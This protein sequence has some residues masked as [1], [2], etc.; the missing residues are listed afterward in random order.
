MKHDRENGTGKIAELEELE[1]ELEEEAG[2]EFLDDVDTAIG[3]RLFQERI[4]WI[5]GDI[6]NEAAK[7]ICTCILIANIDDRGIAVKDREPIRIFLR[8]Y[9]GDADCAFA[10]IDSIRSSSTQV[11]TI[12]VGPCDSAAGLIFMAGHKRYMMPHSG[13]LIHSGDTAMEGSVHSILDAADEL[14][15]TDSMMM[16]YIVSAT[17]IPKETLEQYH[18]AEWKLDAKDCLHYGVCDKIIRNINEVLY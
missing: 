1:K 10:V 8:S 5:D 7:R 16:D 9:G 11:H 2:G 12:N 15:K 6:E 3:L 4:L 17:H 13:V 18:R 14:K